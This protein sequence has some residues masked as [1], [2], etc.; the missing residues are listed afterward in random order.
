MVPDVAAWVTLI[1]FLTS[2][3]LAARLLQA[4]PRRSVLLAYLV[5]LILCF[6][7]IKQYA[8]IKPV[9]PATIA[10]H[11]V[12]VVG[13]SYM[14]FRQIHLVVDA[15]QGQVKGLPLWSYLNYQL[16]L[17]GLMAGPIQRYE[18][19]S[20]DWN[21]LLPLFHD[22]QSVT[23]A[24]LRVFIGVIKIMLLAPP[25]LEVYEAF[26]RTFLDLA[27]PWKA[28]VK[29]A[30]L[31]YLYPAYIYLNFSGYCDMVIAGASLVGLKMPENFNLP[32]LSRNMIDFWTRWHRTLGFWIR[33]Y[34]FNPLYKGMVERWPGK[35]L[36]LGLACY[37]IALFVAGLWHGSTWNFVIFAML[38][39]VGV[40]GAKCWEIYLIRV[41]GRQGFKKYLQSRTIGVAAI[42]ANFHFVCLTVAFFPA[43]LKRTW[44]I[45]KHVAE[46]TL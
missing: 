46:L 2:G 35:A 6:I 9:L 27:T 24:Y 30:L 28:V 25:C 17:F 8:F 13:L 42:V 43:D 40:A 32:F 3:Y 4:F 7:V 29:F 33:D 41:I 11:V 21:R 14:L 5:A 12:V 23:K 26:A 38:N 44:G 18:D 22:F 39:G 15:F 34:L 36:W 1:V 37:F 10:S 45:F 20:H 31:L 16:N 19:F